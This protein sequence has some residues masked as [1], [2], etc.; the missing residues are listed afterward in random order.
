[1]DASIGVLDSFSCTLLRLVEDMM[2]EDGLG[3]IMSYLA[4]TEKYLRRHCH[5]STCKM[6]GGT[7]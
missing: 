1:M 3:I 4:V 5:E 7:T 6:F 2:A